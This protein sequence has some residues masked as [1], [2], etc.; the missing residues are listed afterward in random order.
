MKKYT[1]LFLTAMMCASPNSS[2]YSKGLLDG[3]AVSQKKDVI[4]VNGTVMDEANEPLPGVSILV[5]DEKGL[6]TITD[7]DGHFYLELHSTKDVLVFSYIGYKTKEVVIGKQINLNVVLEEDSKNLDEVVV[8]GYGSQKKL[9]VIGSIANLEP[10]KLQ[11]GSTMSM[12]NNLAGQVPGVIAIRT[13]GEPGYDNADFW[14]RGISSYQGTT[15]PLV[16]IDGV[17]RD[18]NTID[19]EEIESF[20]VLKD[21]SASAMYGVRGANGVIVITTKRGKIAPPSVHLRVEHAFQKPTKLP[22]FLGAPE[23]MEFMNNLAGE[24]NAP[25]TREQIDRTA[26]GYDKELYPDVNWIDAVMKDYSYST[27]ANLTVSGGTPMLRY[28]L[29]GAVFSQEGIMETDKKLDYDTGTSLTRYNLRANVDLNVTKTT[30]LRMNVG[31]YMRQLRKSAASTNSVFQHAWNTPPNVFPIQYSD[32]AIPIRHSSDWNPWA[33]STQGGY[34][35]YVNSRLESLFSIEQDLK[36]LLPGLKAKVVFSFDTYNSNKVERNKKIEWSSVASGRDDEGNLLHEVIR[37]GEDFLGHNKSGEYG[38]NSTYLEASLMYNKIFGGKHSV[39]AMLLYNQSNYDDGDIQPYRHQGLA[40]RLSYTFDRRYVGE[41][42]FGYNGSE[43]F[44]KGKRMGFFPS[45]A[46]GWLVSEEKFWERIRPIVSKL[47][48]RASI[49]LVGNDN[50]GSKRRFAYLSTIDMDGWDYYFGTNA[51]YHYKGIREGEVGVSDLTW[52]TVLKENIGLEIGLWNSLELQIDF[53]KDYRKNIF[54]QRSI[55]P[56]QAGFIKTP[57]ANYGKVENTGMEM[58]LTYN[59][60]FTKDFSMSLRGNFT[61]AKNK[62]TEC[63]EPESVKGTH[64][65]RTGESVK[66]LYGYFADG[67]YADE[68]FNVDGSLKEELPVPTLSNEVRPGDIKYL[69]KNGDG[70]ITEADKGYIG[71]TTVPRLIYG[72][73]GNFQY[74]NFDL[75]IFFQ[76]SGDYY[77]MIGGEDGDEDLGFIPGGGQEIRSNIFSN[78]NDRWTEE[79][80]SQNVFWPRLS[81]GPNTNNSVASTWW[82]KDM[83]FLRLK[84]LEVGYSLPRSITDKMHANSIRFYISGNDLFYFSKFKLW[85]PELATNTGCKYPAMS[86]IMVGVDLNF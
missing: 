38:N 33:E 62:I 85:D 6:G 76:G 11:T 3:E 27:R 64:R 32:G 14:I 54:I 26:S 20:S 56:T 9:S 67:L 35:K 78:Y 1:W 45:A 63:D 72:F 24:D 13:S 60:K 77:R 59:K 28:S 71:G 57:Y 61:Y 40:G 39:D 29:V 23:Y 86:S 30:L 8:V 2:L 52:E 31:G 73:G 5:K 25:F 43:N 69:D 48:L 21:A 75:G 22:D 18:L 17:E 68:D 84:M 80:P 55:I 46:I 66:T 10:Q 34:G 44:A 15:T 79:N 4:R 65:S 49:G 12:A 41:F 70:F 53:F 36:M 83:S 7:V 81:Y 51:E 58:S 82:K 50:I 19:P 16:L 47:K 42:N 74:K 37:V